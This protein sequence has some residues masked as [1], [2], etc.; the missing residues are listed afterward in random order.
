M[1]DALNHTMTYGYDLMSNLTSQTDALGNVTNFEYD[2]F[3]RLKKVKYPAATT[4]ATRLEENYT[5]DLVGNVKTR[6]DTAGRTMTYD[7]DNANR[8]IKI[9][10]ALTQLTQF[11][12]NAR[13]Q[14]TKVTDALSQQYVFTYDA[15]GRQLT[16]TRAGSTM[17]FEYDAVGN[18]TKRTDYMGRETT[19]E[20][21][22]LNRLKKINYLQNF[23]G[24]PSQV[25]IQTVTY[26]YDDLSRLVSAIN[27][28]GT[29]SFTYD[30]RGRLKTETDVFGHVTER[31]YDAA[32]RRTQLKLDG[33]NYAAYAYDIADRLTGITNISDSTTI[34][35]VYDDA[36][37]LAS[38]TY[39]NGVTT[40]YEYDGMSRLT[41]LKDVSTTATLFDRQYAY[42]SANQISQIIEP[43]LS[44][45]FGYDNIDRLTS[46]TGGM[47]ENYIFDGVGNRTSSHL[48]S[49]YT[50]QPFNK[51]TST[52]TANYGYDANGNT[53]S[54]SEGSNFWRYTWDY[55]NRMAEASGRKQKVRYKYDALGRRVSRN[56]GYGK[57]STKFTYEGKDVL[58]DDNSGTL[59]KYLNGRGIDNKLRA[60]SGTN[61]SYFLGDHL[62]ST[63]G[64]TNSSGTLTSSNGY[65][66]FGNSSNQSFAS[67]Y[68]FTG[69]EYDSFTGLQFSR[70]RWYDPS[71][72]R[73]ISEDPIGFAGGDVN[74]YGYVW[75]SP[76]NYRDPLGLDSWGNDFADWLD[77]KI[78][79]ARQFYQ[80]DVQEWQRNG[81]V[82]T[83]AEISRGTVDIFRVG[84]GTGNALF[85][86]DDNGYGRGANVLMDVA[87][88]SAIFTMLAGPIARP[89]SLGT[90]Y[91]PTGNKNFRIAPFGN[92]PKSGFPPNPTGQ[93]PHYHR[94]VPDPKRPGH[95]LPGQAPKRHRPW[96]THKDDKSFLDRF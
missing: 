86:P 90:E 61:V 41:R 78:E 82:D 32:S 42:N 75:N 12:Y 54:K 64:L 51:L 4:G 94:G 46:V 27:E 38:R 96:D 85:D 2:A 34:G 65:D 33:A 11:E 77:E 15:L 25:P 10:D 89:A 16:Q 35:F 40:T 58:L 43:S 13:S 37:R 50:Y 31:I 26:N 6:V 84:S 52:Q 72:G 22:V 56:L 71:I 48:S 83:F 28:A 29:V 47:T 24:V 92:R 39:P 45:L 62:G 3:D 74:L 21:D 69:R 18:R 93:F 73:F 8:L 59:T 14:M 80:G 53:V 5:Y 91:C 68:R 60:Q 67:R 49:T 44:R 1:T 23:N 87:R 79:Y 63:N 7:Y 9:T 55:E 17:T 66:S 20:Y 36:N 88:A 95:S 81:T 30:N 57:E 70:A 19:Y 76:L